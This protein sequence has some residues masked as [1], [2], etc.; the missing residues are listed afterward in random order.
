EAWRFPIS[1]EDCRKY[2]DFER[3]RTIPLHYVDDEEESGVKL[4]RSYPHGELPE[5]LGSILCDIR[6]CGALHS[7]QF[8]Q[9]LADLDIAPDFLMKT[10]IAVPVSINME[11]SLV[12]SLIRNG[13]LDAVCERTT[14]SVSWADMNKLTSMVEESERLHTLRLEIELLQAHVSA[15]I[16]NKSWGYIPSSGDYDVEE[17]DA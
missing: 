16:L 3:R 10:D 12:F 15:K 2:R 5:E 6:E 4:R 9:L 11:G 8:C 1:V 13:A 17:A 7:D 14:V